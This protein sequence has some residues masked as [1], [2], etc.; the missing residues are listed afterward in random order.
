MHSSGKIN[1]QARFDKLFHEFSDLERQ[2]DAQD[3]FLRLILRRVFFAIDRAYPQLSQ[4]CMGIR[5]VL[6][7]AGDNFLPLDRLRPLTEQLAER[8]REIEAN[9][10][11][12][13]PADGDAPANN[14]SLSVRDALSIL[15]ARIAFTEALQERESQ[16]HQE[17]QT[18]ATASDLVMIDRAAALINDM[19]S[20][21]ER[22]KTDL[23]DFLQ[24]TTSK[25]AAIDQY[26]TQGLDQIQCDRD[27][28]IALNTAAREQIND[29]RESVVA[30]TNLAA[31]KHS[32]QQGLEQIGEHLD[33]LRA[34]EEEQLQRA[35]QKIHVML[36]H[37]NQMKSETRSLHGQL[38]ATI[39]HLL[40]DSLT[41]LPSELAMQKRLLQEINRRK[42]SKS[43]LCLAHW[44]MDDFREIN[45]RCGRQAA[46]KMLHIVGK[47]L[48]Q[49]IRRGDMAARLRGED[50]LILM[51]DTDI[52]EAHTLTEAM[53]KRVSATAFRFKGETI[54]IT[55]SCG[56][57]QYRTGESDGELLTRAE[58][59]LNKSKAQGHNHCSIA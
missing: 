17:L 50:F 38:K 43:P 48:G 53:R 7:Q 8:I 35:E 18:D 16:L 58:A 10:D 28:Q 14:A 19:H 32:V 51:P 47:T 23:V 2:T 34:K 20:M 12:I 31:L 56:L 45:T 26:A 49:L 33:Q 42:H 15:L 54:R 13:L 41:G 5:A 24:Q 22:E 36:R 46:D 3:Q 11:A 29:V 1:Y 52:E 9:E 59:A 27:A 37:I 55:I 39:H 44:D 4:E 57:V 30:S 40:H 25:L 21:D 6:H